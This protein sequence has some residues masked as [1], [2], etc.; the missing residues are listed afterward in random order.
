MAT[1]ITTVY[2]LPGTSWIFWI[3]CRG[4]QPFNTWHCMHPSISTR[5]TPC[6]KWGQLVW[7]WRQ[8]VRNSFLLQ[9]TGPHTAQ[10]FS[11]TNSFVT[12]NN[13]SFTVFKAGGNYLLIIQD[14]TIAYQKTA[15]QGW[16]EALTL[17]TVFVEKCNKAAYK[18]LKSSF[19]F[20]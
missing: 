3:Y 9:Q 14:Y 15:C 4:P 13:Y 7:T 20:T 12:I 5:R 6:Y 8:T 19:I 1:D 18:Y 2:E 16:R 10:Y 11:L 17:N